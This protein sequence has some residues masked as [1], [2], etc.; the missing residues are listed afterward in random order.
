MEAGEA[1]TGAGS[2]SANWV[3]VGV[4]TVLSILI[5]RLLN[6]IEKKLEDHQAHLGKL[7]LVTSNH[8]LRLTIQEEVAENWGKQNETLA[9]TIIT[10]MR[11]AQGL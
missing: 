2:I 11:A 4:S 6:K 1:I 7:D 3:L 9:N 8:E 5:Y 10:K